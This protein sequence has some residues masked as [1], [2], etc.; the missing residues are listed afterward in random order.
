MTVLEIS[1]SDFFCSSFK[2]HRR[3]N[4]DISPVKI[5]EIVKIVKKWSKLFT[6]MWEKSWPFVPKYVQMTKFKIS[7]EWEQLWTRMNF[8]PSLP[9]N[10]HAQKASRGN[11]PPYNSK[12]TFSQG[13]S[14]RLGREP[15]RLLSSPNLPFTISKASIHECL[16]RY[17]RY[18]LV[19]LIQFWF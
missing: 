9:C 2:K 7:P 18:T 1:V 17:L 19:L 11:V 8:S 12:V 3:Q 10:I 13:P 4:E 15:K 6:S 16:M 14:A 5:L